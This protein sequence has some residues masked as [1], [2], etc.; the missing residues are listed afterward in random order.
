MSIVLS[1]LSCPADA[2]LLFFSLLSTPSFSDTAA[3]V[4]EESLE[5]DISIATIWAGW[6]DTLV[7]SHA[8]PGG[9]LLLTES[10]LKYDLFDCCHLLAINLVTTTPIATHVA[11]A[12]TQAIAIMTVYKLGCCDSSSPASR[13]PA[14]ASMMDLGCI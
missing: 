7:D 13:Y 2:S 11:M 10:R 14:S 3:G 5:L 8:A 12:D 6:S 1:L 4:D 9:S